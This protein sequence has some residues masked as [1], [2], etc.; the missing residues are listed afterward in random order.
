MQTEDY[1]TEENSG[2]EKKRSVSFLAKVLDPEGT[3]KPH[4]NVA[5]LLTQEELDRIGGKVVDQY[6][7]D[8]ESRSEWND[9]IEAALKISKQT[10]EARSEP[11]QGASN[12][13]WPLITQASIMFAARSYPAIIQGRE[14]VHCTV[15]G[16]DMQNLKA[17]RAARVSEHM[18]WQLLHEMDSWE[19]DLDKLLHILPV[20]GIVFKK[21]YRDLSAD[22]NRSDLLTPEQV[23][24]HYKAKNMQTVRRIT[25]IHDVYQ[26]EVYERVAAGEW[27][28]VDLPLPTDKNQYREPDPPHVIL[29]QHRY[30][31]L[32]GD[33]YEEPWI[34]VVHHESRKVLRIYPRFSVEGVKMEGS[35]VLR[36]EP[37]NYF[38]KFGFIPN[39]DGSL[40]DL[41]FGSLMLPLNLSINSII[42]QLIDSGRK[43]NMDCG[44]IDRSVREAPGDVVFR[45]GEWK[46]TDTPME[47][48]RDKI[49]P[50]PSKEPSPALINL[51]TMLVDQGEAIG[52][53]KDV[54]Q[55]DV[56]GANVPATTV[57]AVIEQG[58]KQ[59][60]AIF[61]RIYR[62]LNQEFQMLFKLNSIYMDQDQYFRLLDR[63]DTVLS[64][65]PEDYN[66]EDLDVVPVAD[67]TMV[68]D[69]QRM[70]R[71]QAIA[72]A[73]SGRP[74]INED[75]I[76]MRLANALVVEGANRLVIP[77][78]QRQ[79]PPEDPRIQIERDRYELDVAKFMAGLEE[80]AAKIAEIQAKTMELLASAEA[81]EIGPQL[82]FYTDQ[83]K[84]LYDTAKERIKMVG[85]PGQ[86]KGAGEA[87]SMPE[88]EMEMAGLPGMTGL[89]EAGGLSDE[90]GQGL[91]A[92]ME[93]YGGD[94]GVLPEGEGPLQ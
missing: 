78:D 22:K 34:V 72:Q 35:K 20:T 15:L 90:L 32:D 52:N 23:V 51:L 27:L 74:G 56:P 4:I 48:L 41:G 85:G 44:W 88:K 67:P 24:V 19:E 2:I 94:E 31:D 42:N 92:G 47:N 79:P 1:V 62:S 55:G 18:S 6:D 30:L 66:V 16:E 87:K 5:E 45:P 37:I 77:P 36:I 63:P 83:M 64:V 38:V 71:A 50:M 61:K 28:D 54:L 13:R 12:I 80:S 8:V 68:S 14:V 11:W 70:A 81:K 46:K 65:M 84:M 17:D 89:E 33:G 73:L 93:G 76:T 59:Y 21:I 40:Y 69:V 91:G 39:P 82:Q 60:T 86:K 58:M 75:E 25:H 43:A 57:L 49:L 7:I 26:S 9:I 53:V 10:L 3:G 29:E